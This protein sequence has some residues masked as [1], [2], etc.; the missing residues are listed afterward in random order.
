MTTQSPIF[1][2]GSVIEDALEKNCELWL[3][4]QD[5]RKAYDSV[6]WEHLWNSLVRIKMCHRFIRFFGGIHNGRVNRVMTDFGLTDGYKEEVFSLLLWHIFYDPLL[7][8]VK[9]QA[10]GCG[11]RLNSHFISGCGR[12]ESR[13]SISSFFAAGAFVDD[14]IWTVAIPINCDGTTSSLLISGS[15]I[16]I[17]KKGKL[18][19]YL[20]IYLSTEGLSKPSLAK[21]HS[22]VRFFSNLVLRKTVSDKQFSYLV[23]AV[24][25]PI[26]GYRT[27]FSYAPI[28]A[29]EKCDTLICKG[30]RSKSGLPHDFSNDAIHH[31][32]LYGLKT[33]E[34]VQAESKM[35]SVISFANSVGILGC[36]FSHQSHDF[37]VFCWCPLYPLQCPVCVKVNPLNNFLAGVVH[38][39]SRCDLSLGGFLPSAFH[40]QD[41]TPM[42]LVL[43]PH[44]P[45]P[46]WFELS[47]HFLG[48]VSF[49]SVYSTLLADCGSSDVLW[50]H[51][52]GIIGAGLFNSNVGHLS[53][54]TNGSLSNLE[55][56][57]IKAGAAV[58]FENIGMSLGVEVSGLMSSTLT[59]LQAIALALECVPSSHSVDLFSDSQAALNACKLE[60]E[61]VYPDFKNCWHLP[62][63]VDEC[64]L[65]GGEA[66]ISGN[67]R[68]FV[69][70]IFQSVHRA[71][72]EISCGIRVVVDSLCTD[73][74]WFRSSLVWHPDSHMAAGFTSKR[75]AGFWTY[76]IKALH[77][78]L[79]VTM[80]KQLYNKRYPSVTCLFCSNV[81]VSDYVFSCLFDANGRAQLLNT[82]AA[83]WGV[84]SS[85][86]HSSSGVLQ[87]MSTCV[88][89]ISV[90]T[91]LCKDFVFKDWFCESVSV[92]KDSRIAG[93]TIVVFMCEFSLA[94]WEDIWLIH[95][96]HRTFM[97]KNGLIPCD[98]SVPVSI[99]GLFLG[100][101]SG[102]TQLLDVAEAIGVG[103][104]FHNGSSSS[105]KAPLNASFGP[106]DGSFSQKKRVS[107]RN[108]KHSGVK[109][110]VFLAKPYSDG[111]MYSDMES[112][113]SNSIVDEVLV[114]S[115][116][117]SFLGSA[118]ITL[119]AKRVKN[120][121][122]CGAP[123]GSLNYNMD[124]DDSGFLPPPLGIFLERK[125]LDSKIIKTQV[126]VA[127]KKF[128]ALNIN[129]SAVE[130]KLATAKTQ[131]IRKLFSKINGFG[132]ATI[133][134]KFEGI[135]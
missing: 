134:S 62:H 63:S 15:P 85:L 119:K 4:L 98:G 116:N 70:D 27:Q 114:N 96:K 29:C 128:F 67:S 9:K 105:S 86:A 3:V 40:H 115:S 5:M 53:V 117:K 47:V 60:M 113:S 87:L 52:F 16:S 32:S 54:Y 33:F 118:T 36:L 23:L 41:G 1:A 72:W 88:F 45:V 100:L 135:I 48:G 31:P 61:L 133:P 30:L 68:H 109:S 83:V 37:Q 111:G 58:F 28:S 103:F 110:G 94:F 2:I 126:K 121:L 51:K 76:F 90:S 95:A 49:L 44:G 82:H 26:I 10:D 84:C 79:S 75:T 56:V 99:S 8:E 7:C 104:G 78:R 101:S 43:D 42:S 129:L 102:V 71:H 81:E 21:A 18:H 17:T 131:V 59:E 106:A 64:Y 19:C 34:Q 89:D 24:L 22:D 39:F 25:F 35:A 38:I 122:A 55:T 127:V 14:T 130:G 20:G 107:L 65:R 108:V 125:W 120:N 69:W 93:Q 91:A 80:H 73:I 123:L 12:A 74:D 77:H 112:N 97:E 46:V 6:G 132:G 57:D 92:F 11:Y 124:D 50:S 13:T 66:A